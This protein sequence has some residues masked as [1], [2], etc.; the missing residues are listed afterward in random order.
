VTTDVDAVLLDRVFQPCA[1]HLA[2]WTTCFGLARGALVVACE[3]QALTLFWDAFLD[4]SAINLVLSGMIAM[5]TLFGAQQAWGL[6]K[7]VERQARS[8]GMNVRRIT[9]RRQRMIW[10]GVSAF[11]T[12]TLSP[13]ADIRA[14]SAILACMGWVALIYFVSCTPRPPAMRRSHRL[15]GAFS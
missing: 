4:G 11:C 8:G 15:A 6:I 13:H 12:A 9:L 14:V 10:L 2:E 7:R 1:D 3:S 5:L